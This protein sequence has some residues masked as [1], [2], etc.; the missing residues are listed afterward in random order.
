MGF[1]E[2]SAEEQAE[3]RAKQLA[4][5]RRKNE[6]KRQRQPSAGSNSSAE[7]QGFPTRISSDE[8]FG[9]T[10]GVFYDPSIPASEAGIQMVMQLVTQRFP[11]AETR[12]GEVVTAD[13]FQYFLFH[14][15]DEQIWHHRLLARLA[16][17]GFFTITS[18]RDYRHNQRSR[19]GRHDWP[20]PELQPFYSVVDWS[21]FR[22]AKHVRKATTE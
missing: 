6:A 22:G 20:L 18:D 8:Y 1:S 5:K 21:E 12:Q 9:A 14:G 11:V 2:L 10:R 15:S 16:W 7:Q 19:A 4:T 13:E 3:V 17:E